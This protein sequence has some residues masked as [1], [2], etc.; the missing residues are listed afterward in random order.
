MPI[1][2][3]YYVIPRIVYSTSNPGITHDTT[4]GMENGQ[5][6]INISTK[7]VFRCIDN[8]ANAAKWYT[9]IHQID[10]L[11]TSIPSFQTEL[12]RA[13]TNKTFMITPEILYNTSSSIGYNVTIPAA[14]NA[15]SIGSITIEDGFTVQVDGTWTIV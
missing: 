10:P 7:D 12:N 1:G 8:T 4:M 3:D 14:A 15:M 6:W 13:I 5:I 11:E 2:S 9:C